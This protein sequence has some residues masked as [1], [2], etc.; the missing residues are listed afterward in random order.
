MVDG[1]DVVPVVLLVELEAVVVDVVVVDGVTVDAVVADVV[2]TVPM[3]VDESTDPGSFG[4]ESPSTSATS[5]P[6]A[7]VIGS[8]GGSSLNAPPIPRTAMSPA[9]IRTRF[10]FHQGRV[11]DGLPISNDS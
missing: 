8:G 6:E 9:G 4:S 10:R 2:A 5:A 7:R 1:A 11:S 3:V